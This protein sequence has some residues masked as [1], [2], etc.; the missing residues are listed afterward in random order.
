MTK[1]PMFL[2]PYYATLTAIGTTQDEVSQSGKVTIPR[3]FF[4]TLLRFVISGSPFDEAD[5]LT[6]HPDIRDAVKQRQLKSGRAHFL[7]YGYFEG[8]LGGTAMV[9]ED[10]YL[11]EYPDVAEAVRSGGL[12]SATEHYRT[13]GMFEWRLPNASAKA[14]IGLWKR[15]LG[16]Y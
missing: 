15:A 12:T 10:W 4:E 16:I 5:Y 9:D 11:A 1:T 14:D 13:T 2:P 3:E 6:L 8:R 7:M